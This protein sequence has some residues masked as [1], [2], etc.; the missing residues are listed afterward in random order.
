MYHWKKDKGSTL[1]MV[2]ICVAFVSILGS[3]LVSVS[4]MNIQMKRVDQ[5]A[6]NNFYIVETAFDEIKTGLEEVAAD[7][8]E[9]A[10]SEMM[11]VYTSKTE[12]ERNQ[13]YS[14]SFINQMTDYLKD[15]V[16]LV[17]GQYTYD[18]TLIDNF[19]KGNQVQL[20][21]NENQNLLAIDT[22]DPSMPKYLT[23][24]N[25]RITY[26]D[27]EGYNTTLASDLT[28]YVPG[29]NLDFSVLMDPYY[30]EYSLIADN[31]IVLNNQGAEVSGNVYAGDGG[32]NLIGSADLTVSDAT[33]FVTRGDLVVSG[34][35]SLTVNAT[36]IWAMNI[37]TK[38]LSGSS[39]AS[40]TLN[41]NCYVGDDLTL[42]AEGSTVSI[43]GDYYGYSY[44]TNES[45][46][47]PSVTPTATNPDDSSAI[48]INGR[49]SSLT[50]SGEDHNL[51]IAG[52]AYIDPSSSAS[53]DTTTDQYI[54]TGESLAVK[55]NQYAY[56]VPSECMFSSVNPVTET[57][58]M[59]NT[60]VEVDYTK[61]ES[62]ITYSDYA[63]GYYKVFYNTGTQKLVYYYMKFKSEAKANEYLRAYY[64]V[65]EPSGNGIGILDNRTGAFLDD[66]GK[67]INLGDSVSSIASF[68]N[69]FTYNI[70]T[71]ESLLL[72]STVNLDEYGTDASNPE[73]LDLLN[74]ITLNIAKRYY[75]IT[76]TLVSY[77]T[78]EPSSDSLFESIIH[79]E[80]LHRDS[81][82]ESGF[83]GGIRQI[84][85]GDSILYLI[86]NT[87]GNY[88]LPGDNMQGIVIAT[89]SITVPE[90]YKFTGLLL[91]GGTI[92]LGNSSFV[93]AS[94]SIVKKIVTDVDSEAHRYFRDYE[95]L[96][97]GLSDS[98]TANGI[99]ISEYI[100]YDNWIRN[101]D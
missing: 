101:E 14:T 98:S 41:G 56:L 1:L 49:N 62:G 21:I 37:L 23:I 96:T 22:S 43:D 69:L 100:I 16:P 32:I 91:A 50:F 20:E 60:G 12:T 19:I 73:M 26:T 42:N 29:F 11:K 13:I 31:S 63:D 61:S 34:G 4:V 25:I 44:G 46:T 99:N 93:V 90:N 66:N 33:N 95:S 55:G 27:E 83:T 8:L 92:S 67:G 78:E 6:K 52:R 82:N 68:G 71:K 70:A 30:S 65:N 45:A 51:L 87:N 39:F 54:Q 77:N 40:L 53:V 86:D 35:S 81:I 47:N 2:I 57:M 94:K 7:K 64:K 89:G 36:N 84:T 72:S 24:K 59:G 85:V 38:K 74:D 10:F 9:F 18:T 75:S 3:V 97:S 28:I 15:N 5:Y 79:S 80:N 48:V 17:G 58:L 76:R 88:T